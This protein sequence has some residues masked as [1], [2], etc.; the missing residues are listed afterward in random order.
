MAVALLGLG[1]NHYESLLAFYTECGNSLHLSNYSC[2]SIGLI[3]T[4]GYT[5]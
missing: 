1:L 3:L 2:L 4:V 5:Y